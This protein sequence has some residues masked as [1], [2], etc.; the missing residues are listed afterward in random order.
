MR[1]GFKLEHPCCAWLLC[2]DTATAQVTTSL[3]V[4]HSKH[5]LPIGMGQ[6]WEPCKL[7]IKINW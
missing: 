6:V 4:F 2:C 3:T 7:S 1:E 5:T